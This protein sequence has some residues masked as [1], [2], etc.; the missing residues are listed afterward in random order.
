MIQEYV[1][2]VAISIEKTVICDNEFCDNE[3]V[4]KARS[5]AGVN[6]MIAG[7]GWGRIGYAGDLCH[8][9]YK[10]WRWDNSIVGDEF[11]YEHWDSNEKPIVEKF[12]GKIKRD[13]DDYYV[14]D[15][16]FDSIDDKVLWTLKA[17][18]KPRRLDL[19]IDSNG[20]MY[21]YANDY[22]KTWIRYRDV[23]NSA[24]N[25]A[26]KWFSLS[27]IQCEENRKD[28]SVTIWTEK[29]EDK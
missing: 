7:S 25:P 1:E 24:K 27:D 5:R 13:A 20:D 4:F 28:L 16:K 6:A 11:C 21:L 22:N 10:S 12:N 2:M 15:W 14:T 9:C 19:I 8:E 26:K 18:T 17:I 29:M 3:Q 23:I